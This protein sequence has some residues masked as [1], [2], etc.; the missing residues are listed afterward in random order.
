MGSLIPPT[1]L[2]YRSRQE[3]TFA[4]SLQLPSLTTLST[5]KNP[6]LSHWD[7][8]FLRIAEEVRFWSKDPGTKVG[9]V[10]VKDRRILSTGYN[11]FPRSISDDLSRYN[12][13]D[14]KLSVTV[15]AET[16]AVL[17]AA[18]NGTKVE[19]STLY[20]TFPPCSRCASAIIQAG[21]T[22]IV[23]PNPNLSPERWRDNF[24][25]ASDLFCEAGIKVLYYADSDLWTIDSAPFVG[26][27]G[28]GPSC[29]GRL[30]DKAK[31]QTS[32]PWYAAV[33]TVL[34][35]KIA[36]ILRKGKTE[37]SAGKNELQ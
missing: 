25:E 11:G 16:N 23:C 19:D 30:E 5:W 17:N 12:N 27:N 2:T 35:R 4:M 8:R 32:M 28:L 24:L 29:T 10:L 13:R 21:V 15:H 31:T 14:Y 36:R 37:E 33:W 6:H 3:T 9:C 34:K 7:V 22:R 26:Q 18:K 20:V 1:T